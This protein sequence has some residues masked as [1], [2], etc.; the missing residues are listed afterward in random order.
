VISKFSRT[1]GVL[2]SVAA[3]TMVLQG[4]VSGEDLG[5]SAGV[6]DG[7]RES[8]QELSIPPTVPT[9]PNSYVIL[10]SGKVSVGDRGRV[11]A[12]HIGSNSPAGTDAVTAGSDSRI[13]LDGATVGRRVVLQHRAQAGGLFATQVSAQ[14]ARYV[15]RAPFAVPPA[16]PAVDAVT[17]GTTAVTVNS[18]Q[19]LTRAAGS[20]GA[21]TVNGTLRLSGGT[22]SIQSL[23]LGPDGVVTAD[24]DAEVRVA[25]KISGAD[26]SKL[27]GP[28]ASGASGLRLV[29]AGATDATGGLVLGNDA[30]LTA[31]VLSK[32][33][34][35]LG[36]RVTGIGAIG[37]TNVTV[38]ND[39]SLTFSGGFECN[40][41]TV[42]ADTNPCTVDR[43][44]NGR[45]AHP[46]AADGTSCDD[47]NACTS[48]DSC[49][50]GSCAGGAP[51]TCDD[52]VF[53]NGSESC[54]SATGC[55]SGTAPDV[56]DGISCTTDSCDEGSES[57]SHVP[58]DAACGV[59][60]E[61][62][63]SLGCVEDVGGTGGSSSGGGSGMGGLGG[64]VDL[65]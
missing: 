56:T 46:A 11:S 45:C 29:V 62:S 31:L 24:A 42:C 48:G 36:E 47:G 40:T 17:P 15:S 57:I 50:A 10:A 59:G 20:Y 5:N 49:G 38:G 18:G 44:T 37:A 3:A 63:T 26:R 30:K 61:C 19:T 33:R 53:C 27:L 43:C 34:V 64:S 51:V 22:Y 14:F 4:C 2:V 25:G 65:E 39:S 8:A 41:D 35:Q 55:V 28:T 16:V 58:D 12:G 54:N 7:V 13:V 9:V 32:A 1:T 60:F 6:E 52:G 23:T 21:V